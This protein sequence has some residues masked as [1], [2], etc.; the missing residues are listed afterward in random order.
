MNAVLCRTVWCCGLAIWLTFLPSRA[1]AQA[2]ST[3]AAASH[4]NSAAD[5][6]KFLAGG[7]VAFVTH[8]GAHFLLDEAFGAQP[9]IKSVTFGP[10][11]F[12]AIIHREI[13][14]RREFVV[15]SAGLWVQ[16]GTS[17]WLLSRRPALARRRAPFAKG[18]LAFNVLA[19][20]GY[21]AVAMARAGPIERDTRGI[22]E[23]SRTN[24][25]AVGALVMAPAIFDAYR[26]FKPEARWAVWASRAAK[27]G[28]VL[29]IVR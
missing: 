18:I 11:P 27:I 8:E 1:G 10:F 2:A 9:G 14:P 20:F 15:S 29:L 25:R 3:S 19:S 16:D 22:A 24:E 12:F 6:V 28:S 21:G 26:Y 13:S 5:T 4:G 23:G 7:A 17:E